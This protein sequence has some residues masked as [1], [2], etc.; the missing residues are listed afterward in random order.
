MTDVPEEA[1][2]HIDNLRALRSPSGLFLASAQNVSTGYD[3]AWLRDNFYMSLAFEQIGDQETVAETWRA[4]LNIFS[5]HKDKLSWATQHKPYA[6]W[7]YIHA[8]YHPETFDE[9]W[10]EWGN[11]QNDAVGAIL[12]ALCG[13]NA[14]GLDILNSSEDREVVQLLVNYLNT[15]EYWHDPDNGVWEE[16]EEVHASSIGPCVAAL[17]RLRE[18][19]WLEIPEGMIEKG[20][21]ALGKLLPRESESKY[22]DLALLSLIYPYNVLDKET[23]DTVLENLEYQFDR[24]RGVIRYKS[25]R[26]YNKNADGHSE[27]AE[28]TMGFPWLSIIYSQRGEIEKAGHY[29]DKTRE[30][31]TED[32]KLPELY[33]SNSSEPNENIPLGWSE[34]LFVVALMEYEKATTEGTAE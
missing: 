26:Y 4:M 2:P 10:E 24:D 16:Y 8:R 34:S 31:M 21:E 22:C 17:K 12:F 13:C 5:K 25:D 27:E 15:I 20:E 18:Y 19:D 32:K 9:Y 1:Q 14:A 23:A 30:V 6:S 7:Q 33:Y 28:W 3:K 11:K 29:L